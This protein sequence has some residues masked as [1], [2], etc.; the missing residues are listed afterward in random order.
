MRVV[1]DMEIYMGNLI[2]PKRGPTKPPYVINM[3]LWRRRYEIQWVGQSSVWG[4][5]ESP[6]C[7]N[8]RAAI[9]SSTHRNFISIKLDVGRFGISRRDNINRQNI[10]L[11][12]CIRMLIR[13]I[14]YAGN[15]AIP[16]DFR[17]IAVW[18]RCF[19]IPKAGGVTCNGPFPIYGIRSPAWSSI[20]G[21]N[22]RAHGRLVTS[23]SRVG[24]LLQCL[25]TWRVAASQ[26]SKS[27]ACSSISDPP[28][29][30]V[31]KL[32]KGPNSFAS[33]LSRAKSRLIRLEMIRLTPN[34]Q[35]SRH[36]YLSVSTLHSSSAHNDL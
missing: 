19:Y 36:S 30:Q 21:S 15:H 13:T 4:Q 10:P 33:R 17:N 11:L 23:R 2:W 12:S 34:A 3:P 6:K 9:L 26:G 8:R 31:D 32:R 7:G 24:M 22:P 27:A 14:F 20:G 5:S 1:L 16:T 28:S 35:Y 29:S 18:R 25:L